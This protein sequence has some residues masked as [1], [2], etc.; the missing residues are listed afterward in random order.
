MASWAG[1]PAAV[2]DVIR[3]P[4]DQPNLRAAIGAARDDDVVLVADGVYD[5]PQNRNLD[6]RGKRIA[7]RSAGGPGRCVI[8]CGG[9][10]RAFDFHHG[11]TTDS[12]LEGFTIRNGSAHNGGAI[13]LR[14]ESGP[15]IRLRR[16][17]R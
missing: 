17:C 5:G 12:V 13:L 2:A 4:Q 10:Q 14:H 3:V 11:E 7:V 9:H 15:T 6:F 8:D 1:G 16:S